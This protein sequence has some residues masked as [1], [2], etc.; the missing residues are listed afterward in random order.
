[1]TNMHI[2]CRPDKNIRWLWL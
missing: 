2:Q 1:M